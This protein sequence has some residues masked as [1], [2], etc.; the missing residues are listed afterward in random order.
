VSVTLKSLLFFGL[1]L[2]FP[3]FSYASVF[4]L[5]DVGSTTDEV[6]ITTDIIGDNGPYPL[7]FSSSS[8]QLFATTSCPG[9]DPV[10]T[11]SVEIELPLSASAF[12]L[13]LTYFFFA[14]LWIVVFVLMLWLVRKFTD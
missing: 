8:T 1:F 3:Y 10:A 6:G 4:C 14:I 2:L 5:T 7:E 12:N 9:I 13:T 11:S